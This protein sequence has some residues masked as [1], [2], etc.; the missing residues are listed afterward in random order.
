MPLYVG[1]DGAA[2]R[3]ARL[4]VGVNGLARKVRRAYIGV[5][6]T[7]RRFYAADANKQIRYE[8]RATP[9]G[10]ARRMPAAASIP[11]HAVFA[12]GD[13]ENGDAVDT[14]DLL[15]VHNLPDPLFTPRS[16]A[17][18]GGIGEYALFAGGNMQ[19]GGRTTSVEVYTDTLA[20]MSAAPLSSARCYLAASRVGEYL[21]FAGGVGQVFTDDV[22][23]YD[24]RLTHSVAANLQTGRSMLKGAAIDGYAIFAGGRCKNSTE[25]APDTDEVCAY[26][27]LLGRTN[28]APLRQKKESVCTTAFSNVAIVWGGN[29]YNSGESEYADPD[30]ADA[31]TDALTQVAAPS[32]D[33]GKYDWY[34]VTFLDEVGAATSGYGYDCA[35]IIAYTPQLTRVSAPSTEYEGNYSAGQT[36]ALV[37]THGLWAGGWHSARGYLNDVNHITYG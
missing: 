20:H 33:S 9:L 11:G 21:L 10:A 34:S 28:L 8:G 16:N 2:R 3:A 32:C 13:G 30:L 18:G 12:G 19:E 31:Y 25:A 37:G 35:N 27:A 14:Y 22:D 24:A 5:N 26:S 29:I 15:L 23:V 36:A 6:N 7:A 17:A 4:F 1:I